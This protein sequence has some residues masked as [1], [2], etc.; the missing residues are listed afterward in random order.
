MP[1]ATFST[2]SILGLGYVGLPT[3]AIFARSGKSV[4]GVDTQLEK[5]TNI[6]QGRID[7]V[8]PQLQPIVQQ[9]VENGLFFATT[10]PKPADAFIIA[11][12][13]PLT[14][15]QPDISYIQA[16]AL[17]IAPHLSKGNL[18]VLESTSPV[19]TTEQLAKWLKQAR[20]DLRFPFE[21]QTDIYIAYCP[22]RVLPGKAM[23]EIVNN[24]RVI[25]GL[26]EKCTEQAVALYQIFAKGQCLKTDARTAELCKLVENSFRDVNIAF[27]NELSMICDELNINIWELIELAN[28]H[29][30]VNILQPSAGVGGHCVAVDPWFIVSSVPKLA[31]L[32][33]TAREINDKKSQWVV[34]KVK[35]TL[36]ECAIKK[37][38]KLSELTIACLGLT[39]KADIDDLRESA[40]LRITQQIASWHSGNVVAVEPNI[41]SL[42]LNN[43][44]L[45][46]LDDA[47]TQADILVLLVDHSAFKK[48]DTKQISQ[49]Y[50]IDCRG[51]WQK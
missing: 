46:E 32:I 42:S 25:G 34:E 48:V 47:L 31:K 6:N 35:I 5:V 12:P 4:I 45:V 24:D 8:E 15:N 11:V 29:P 26:S 44:E 51:V 36:T 3:A 1:Q 38:C 50:I 33:R 40:A 49:Q 13:T 7:I 20:P 16:A 30:R 2:I 27:A 41:Q 37:D 21:E 22:E 18:I 39:F 9:A 10:T 43:I 17:S 23:E 19:G 28:C 14:N